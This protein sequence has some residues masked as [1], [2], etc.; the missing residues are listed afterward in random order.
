M[1]AELTWQVLDQPH[2]ATPHQ[3][4]DRGPDGRRQAVPARDKLLKCHTV[5]TPFRQPLGAVF[6]SAI[7]IMPYVKRDAGAIPGASITYVN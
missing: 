6:T 7:G 3:F 1:T 2:S 4:H 5:P